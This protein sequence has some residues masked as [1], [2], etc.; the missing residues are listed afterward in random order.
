MKAIYK[1]VILIVFFVVL[2]Q[3]VK[4]QNQE[5]GGRQAPLIH[6]SQ[7][8]KGEPIPSFNE[9]TR[10]VVEFSAS[11]C[12]PCFKAIPH[13]SDLAL[14]YAGTIKFI[15]IYSL[16][17]FKDDPEGTKYAKIVKQMVNEMG[18]K[19]GYAVALDVPSQQTAKDWGITAVPNVFVIDQNKRI[20]WNGDPMGG[21]D[22]VLSQLVQGNFD[23]ATT[24]SRDHI[25]EK[26]LDTL[27]TLSRTASSERLEFVEK[28]LSKYPGDPAFYAPK[29]NL[30]AFNDSKEANKWL[31]W[32]LANGPESLDWVYISE[33]AYTAPKY[34]DFDLVFLAKMRALAQSPPSMQPNIYLSISN[35]FSQESRMKE[36]PEEQ[37]LCMQKAILACHTAQVFGKNLK[38]DS[39]IKEA[40]AFVKTIQKRMVAVKGNRN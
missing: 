13:L 32:M 33:Q 23:M 6:I 2:C 16:S 5:T 37:I 17:A 28:L 9:G 36:Q 12:S 34:P 29:F 3:F 22:D 11:W 38:N 35:V 24:K 39:L 14:K 40:M 4:A 26:E 18:D 19:I 10:Y 15:S 25:R 7:W 20:V 21:L 31:T 30:L 1:N 8:L 27:E